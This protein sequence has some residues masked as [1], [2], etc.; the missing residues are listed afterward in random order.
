M[1]NGPRDDILRR[2][3]RRTVPGAGGR[4]QTLTLGQLGFWTNPHLLLAIAVSGLLQVSIAVFPF[5]QPVFDVPTHS[6][7]EWLV[8]VV[9]ALTPVTV[10]EVVKLIR[11]AL[12]HRSRP[13]QCLSCASSQSAIS[14]PEKPYVFSSKTPESGNSA[15]AYRRASGGSDLVAARRLA[16]IGQ[17]GRMDLF[18]APADSLA[19][20]R[21]VS[22][23]R[24]EADSHLAVA[25]REG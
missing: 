9:L 15:A 6:V 10:I 13:R 8:I 4:S 23:L 18:D 3:V 20:S 2:G 19:Q 16:G 12:S 22:D 11:R 21:P 17:V 14:A 7:I 24:D 5:T 25:E 1:T